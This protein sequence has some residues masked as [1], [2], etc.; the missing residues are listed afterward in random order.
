MAARCSLFCNEIG[1]SGAD[2]ISAVFGRTIFEPLNFEVVRHLS[3]SGSGLTLIPLME[4]VTVI[5]A[6]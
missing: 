3:A 2:Y 5:L 1:F 4:A 6:A